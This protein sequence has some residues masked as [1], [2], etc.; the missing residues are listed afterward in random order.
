MNQQYETGLQ[1]GARQQS[2]TKKL[3]EAEQRAESDQKGDAKQKADGKQQSAGCLQ[4]IGK[5]QRKKRKSA[6]EKNIDAALEQFKSVTKDDF[7]RY[8]YLLDILNVM[9]ICLILLRIID[10]G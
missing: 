4:H 2:E 8:I 9:H 1:S 5:K 3:P 10:I 6:V 7:E